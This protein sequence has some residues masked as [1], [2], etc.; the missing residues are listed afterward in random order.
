MVLDWKCSPMDVCSRQREESPDVYFQNSPD[1][2]ERQHL[3][4]A[5][6]SVSSYR[7]LSTVGAAQQVAQKLYCPL[8][9]FKRTRNAFITLHSIA[10]LLSITLNAELK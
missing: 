8:S 4:P 6:Y 3:D 9:L 2:M 7:R 10:L 5:P 1:C